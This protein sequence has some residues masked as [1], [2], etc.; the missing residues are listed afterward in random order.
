MNHGHA[1]ALIEAALLTLN[2]HKHALARAAIVVLPIAI[3]G[4]SVSAAAAW[5]IGHRRRSATSG[6]LPTR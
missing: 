2:D 3:A 6:R 5:T 1:A 4:L